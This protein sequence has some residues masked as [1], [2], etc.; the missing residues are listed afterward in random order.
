MTWSVLVAGFQFSAAIIGRQTWQ[1]QYFIQSSKL[2]NLFITSIA[3]SATPCSMTSIIPFFESFPSFL[4]FGRSAGILAEQKINIFWKTT[5]FGSSKRKT[6]CNRSGLKT[7]LHMGEPQTVPIPRNSIWFDQ[8]IVTEL[9]LIKSLQC[10]YQSS[11]QTKSFNLWWIYEQERD[12]YS[13]LASSTTLL[14]F[15]HQDQIKPTLI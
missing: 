13:C 2:A 1:Y 12:V 7:L 14:V 8:C 4:K 10:K 11:D 9:N 6:Q 3:N 15:C 5:F